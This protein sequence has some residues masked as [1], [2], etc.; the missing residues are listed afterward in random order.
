MARKVYN[1]ENGELTRWLEELEG[2]AP[3]WASFPKAPSQKTPKLTHQESHYFCTTGANLKDSLSSCKFRHLSLNSVTYY[4]CHLDKL[5]N[6]SRIK[7]RR[8]PSQQLLLNTYQPVDRLIST[9]LL[10]QTNKD[11]SIGKQPLPHSYFPNLTW[12]H[13]TN[14][15]QVTSRTA[16]GKEPENAVYAVCLACQAMQCRKAY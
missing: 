10:K 2:W 5:L 13:F 14:T 3:G 4:L 9:T 16:A 8:V 12:V 7:T 1:G 11:K 6:L 15:I